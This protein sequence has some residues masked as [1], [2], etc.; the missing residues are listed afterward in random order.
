MSLETTVENND[1]EKA[2]RRMNSDDKGGLL[3]GKVSKIDIGRFIRLNIRLPI[4]SRKNI[5]Y[6]FESVLHRIFLL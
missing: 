6:S 2:T 5:S 3:G 4:S 1:T